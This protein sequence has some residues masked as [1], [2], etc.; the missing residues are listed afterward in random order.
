MKK[1]IIQLS[2]GF[3]IGVINGLLGAGG[4]MITVPVLKKMGLEQNDAHANAVAVI[5]PLS[6]LSGILY[7]SK[8]YVSVNDAFAYIPTGLLGALVGTFFL[9]KISPLLLKKVFSVFMIYAGIRLLLR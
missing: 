6:L 4:G 5:L 7:I 8:G 1:N 2:F 9:K 3:L